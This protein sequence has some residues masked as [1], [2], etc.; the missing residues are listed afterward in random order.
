MYSMV[1]RLNR[2]AAGVLPLLGK[3]PTKYPRFRDCWIGK[4][5]NSATERG[6]LGIPAKES[7][8]DY[9]F[10]TIYTRVGGD[11]RK[12]YQDQIDQMKADPLYVEDYDD[13]FAPVPATRIWLIMMV[14]AAAEDL[15]LHMINLTQVFIQADK[16]DEGVY[17]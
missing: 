8:N 1:N 11:N 3:H 5:K 4:V 6:P 12:D 9:S 15:C 14:K 16:R 13:S 2:A 17:W 7:D 10:I